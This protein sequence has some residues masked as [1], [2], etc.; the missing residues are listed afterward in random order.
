MNTILVTMQVVIIIILRNFMKSKKI[1]KRKVQNKKYM[2]EIL[3]IN[4]LTVT[5]P[6]ILL[7]SMTTILFQ[8]YMESIR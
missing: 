8:I 4:Q 1:K 6:H 3:E 5:K 2:T 7:T